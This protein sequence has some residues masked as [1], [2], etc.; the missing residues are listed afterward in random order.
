VSSLNSV[1]LI[2]RLGKEPESRAMPSGSTVCNLSIATTEKWKDKQSG[3]P[4]ERTEWHRVVVF[5]RSGDACAEY[6]SKGDLV[7]V[8]GGIRTRKYTKDGV[9]RYSTEIVAQD[10]QFLHTKGRAGQSQREP[11][12]TGNR[13]AATGTNQSDAESDFDDSIP[14]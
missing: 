2:G 10:V 3:Q 6:L 13:R 4:Q 14:F 12:P 11:A 9:E 8:Q 1:Q 7:F 5:G